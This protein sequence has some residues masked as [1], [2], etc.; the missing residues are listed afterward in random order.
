VS[1]SSSLRSHLSRNDKNNN[2]LD[3][4]A[5]LGEFIPELPTQKKPF[6]MSSL[7]L[8]E[9][10]EIQLNGYV[11][12]LLKLPVHVTQTRLFIEFFESKSCDPKPFV[13][14][15]KPRILMHH[16]L[17]GTSAL[18]SE[19][20]SCSYTDEYDDDDEEF[21]DA[22][23][24]ENAEAPLSSHEVSLSGDDKRIRHEEDQSGL[25]WD[26]DSALNELTLCGGANSAVINFNDEL[27]LE[28]LIEN[29]EMQLNIE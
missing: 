3:P 10:R 5:C 2:P 25:W 20:L 21:G 7:K 18:G 1:L 11:Q 28:E 4:N 23:I 12:R 13:G 24:G 19:S 8:A 26:E 9:S 29:Y 17:M 6:W 27:N 14:D 15:A 22:D 16:D